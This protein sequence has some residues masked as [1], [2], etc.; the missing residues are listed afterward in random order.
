MDYSKYIDHTLLKSDA[1]PDDIFLLCEEAKNLYKNVTVDYASFKTTNKIEYF[2]PFNDAPA[3]DENFKDA[4]FSKACWVTNYCGIGLNSRG[5]YAC[6]VAGSIDRV[7][8]GHNS[9][10]TFMDLTEEKLIDH[11][12]RFCR[13]CGNFKHYAQNNGDF[14]ARCEKQPF[15]N[16]VSKTWEVIYNKK[17]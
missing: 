1:T 3:D 10:E 13:L 17:S 2:S 16:I 4:D 6:A 11:Y 8:N 12:S 9:A 14:I 5:Y 15:K 7:L